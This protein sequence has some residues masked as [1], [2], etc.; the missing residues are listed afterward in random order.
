M[1]KKWLLHLALGCITSGALVSCGSNSSSDA[2]PL[3][4]ETATTSGGATANTRLAQARAYENA[5]KT[6]KAL[7][8][9]KAIC[10]KY[11][12][13]NAAAEARFSQARLLDKQGDLFK[14]FE[15]YQDLIA[16]YP[17]SK[18]YAAAI[19]R[20]EAVAHAAANG[21][22]KNNFLGMK[23]RISPE[24]TEKMLAHVRDNAPRALSAPKAQFA[25]GRI[26]QKD[27]N[28]DKSIAAY[29]RLG[30]DYPNSGPAPEAL[31]QTGRILMIK[32]ERGNHNKANVNRA[33]NIF[34]DLI[35]RYPGHSRAADARK[36]LA[37]LGSQDVQRSFETA[38]FYRKK[39]NTKSA[40]FYYREVLRK[41]KSGS[42]YN[43]AKQRIT[44]LGG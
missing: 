36:Q 42:L 3:S 31:Y 14:A 21:I 34:T 6:G 15:A 19:Q 17:G 1:H 22:I 33:K 40:V 35:Q 16:R 27:G 28:A 2:I 43:Q 11:P 9:Y 39:G 18:H 44:E 29:Q 24:K 25:I 5:G 41:T 12:N 13:S 32:A 26:W 38:E 7:S 23:T 37:K 30:R 8:A 10:K 20:Q 4:S